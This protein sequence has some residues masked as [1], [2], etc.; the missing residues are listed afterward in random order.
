MPIAHRH[1]SGHTSA[2]VVRHCPNSYIQKSFESCYVSH[3]HFHRQ[4]ARVVNRMRNGG[5]NFSAAATRSFP[6]V[7]ATI[8]Y[9]EN[10][11]FAFSTALTCKNWRDNVFEE[12]L[13]VSG[14]IRILIE[15]FHLI[16]LSI[17]IY[18]LIRY[19]FKLH[20]MKWISHWFHL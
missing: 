17:K 19:Q 5:G 2:T 3:A 9:L 12:L 13:W 1:C 20:I 11:I 15:Y 14:I 6:N 7:F 18:S 16:K 4:R 10:K 8:V